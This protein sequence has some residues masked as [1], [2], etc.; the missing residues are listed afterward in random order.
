[1]RERKARELSNAEILEK[2]IRKHT[3]YMCVCIHIPC[4]Y[5]YVHN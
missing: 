2:A 3:Y 4:I 5:I 1:M